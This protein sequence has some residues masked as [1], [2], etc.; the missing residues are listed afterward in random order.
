MVSVGSIHL[1]ASNLPELLNALPIVKPISSILALQCIG[2][3]HCGFAIA[4][5]YIKNL[6]KY[7]TR[8]LL[9]VLLQRVERNLWFT[10]IY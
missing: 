4:W 9:F 5:I 2:K 1:L 6:I 10:V 3:A 7:L 8:F